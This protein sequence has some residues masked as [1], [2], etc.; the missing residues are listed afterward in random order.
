MATSNRAI[1]PVLGVDVTATSSL[2]LGSTTSYKPDFLLGSTIKTSDG[3]H[4]YIQ[5]SATITAGD[6]LTITPVTGLAQGITTTLATQQSNNAAYYIGVANESLVVGQQGWACI[7]GS[8]VNGIS[9][10]ASCTKAE[11]LY[12]TATAGALSTTAT[13]SI[14]ISG[15]EATVTTTSAAVVAGYCSNPVLVT[16]TVN[17]I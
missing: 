10:A 13:S 2:F 7:K 3:E 1:S 4:M 9:I 8:P 12:T 14:L 6:V 5:C 17:N 16:G 15:I 11:P